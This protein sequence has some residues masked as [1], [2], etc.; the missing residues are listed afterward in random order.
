[1]EYAAMMERVQRTHPD[2]EIAGILI[3]P[4][5]S[6]G[7]ELLVGIVQDQLWGPVLTL[8]LGGIWTEVFK[9]TSVRLLP[10][11][12]DEIET[13]L[14]ELRGAALLRGTRGQ[15]QVDI[16]A[17]SEVIYRISRLALSLGPRLNVLEI[18]PLLVSASHV[19]A[20]DVLVSWQ[21]L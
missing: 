7:V 21:D 13:M 19:E 6:A 11:Q 12:R 9:D 17:L 20:L 1:M 10:L 18:N 3:S 14:G 5:R 15:V 8:G 4:M 16:H 2:V